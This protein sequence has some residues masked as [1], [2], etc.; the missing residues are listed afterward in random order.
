MRNSWVIGCGVGFR[1]DLGA[2]RNAVGGFWD[3]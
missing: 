1:R 2:G 3:R